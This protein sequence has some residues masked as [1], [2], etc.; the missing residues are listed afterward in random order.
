LCIISIVTLILFWL[1]L[2]D[3]ILKNNVPLEIIITALLYIFLNFIYTFITKKSNINTHFYV[4]N[5]TYSIKRYNI[6]S[7]IL[8][9][10]KFKIYKLTINYTEINNTEINYDYYILNSDYNNF[11]DITDFIVFANIH[12][13]INLNDINEIKYINTLICVNLIKNKIRLLKIK[14][15]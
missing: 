2:A 13:I 11:K 10:F 15:I 12:D 4:C 14:N 6:Y 5:N 1:V 9:I 8:T 3:T 7:E